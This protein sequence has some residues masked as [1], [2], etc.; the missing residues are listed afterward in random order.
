VHDIQR[1]LVQ[2]L[3]L[4]RVTCNHLHHLNF[5]GW[6]SVPVIEQRYIY[7]ILFTCSVG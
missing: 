5:Y 6:S 3:G 7:D 4:N 1:L 2:G